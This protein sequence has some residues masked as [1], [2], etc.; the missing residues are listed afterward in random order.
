MG[1]SRR[2][3]PRTRGR[4]C[5]SASRSCGRGAAILSAGIGVTGLLTY[6]YF[7][8]ASHTLPKD[9]YGGI[10]LLWSTVFIVVS[11]LYRPVEQ[12][13]SRTI[14]DRAARGHSGNDHLRVAATIQLGLGAL[15][16]VLALLF[17]HTLEN[18]LFNGSR[19]LFWVL[20]T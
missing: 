12:L 19:T 5:L 17:R 15:F 18:D 20:F 6:A 11:V 13:L 10:S 8:L 14:A 4:C 7:A 3:V 9:Q 16:A 1:R 2:H